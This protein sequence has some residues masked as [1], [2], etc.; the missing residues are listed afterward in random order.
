M[1][2]RPRKIIPDAAFAAHANGLSIRAIRDRY[3]VGRTTFSRALA[4]RGSGRVKCVPC[5]PAQNSQE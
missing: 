2:G 3:H 4:D 5:T 1:R